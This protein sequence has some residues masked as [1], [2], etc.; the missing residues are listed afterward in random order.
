MVGIL[1]TQL[2]TNKRRYLVGESPTYTLI[3]AIPGSVI[4]WSSF[5]NGLA[6]GEWEE[7]YGDV[8]GANGGVELVGGK[9]T[10]DDVGNWQKIAIIYPPDGSRQ[11]LQT[12]FS[13]EQPAQI[14]TPGPTSQNWFAGNFE[15]QF[16]GR[17]VSI[18]RGLT[19]A[20]GAGILY[21][22]SKF[23]GGGRRR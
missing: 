17:D 12:E 4:K 18:N 6:T 5:K 21:A 14:Q 7:S 22:L 13:V 19:L 2:T 3:S 20:G 15:F 1:T 8:I 23:S 9:W 11:T 10:A 16:L